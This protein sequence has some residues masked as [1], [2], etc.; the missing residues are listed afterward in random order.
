MP[1]Y[2]EQRRRRWYA[3]LDVP[4]DLRQRLGSS[5][6]IKSLGTESKTEAERLVL[7]LIAEWKA[8]FHATRNLGPEQLAVDFNTQLR[9]RADLEKASGSKGEYE[10]LR[11]VL[12]D[13]FTHMAHHDDASAKIAQKVTFGETFPLENNVEKWLQSL[14]NEP[15]TIDMKRSDLVRLTK[16]FK[17]SHELTKQ[18]VQTWVHKMQVNDALQPATARRIVSSCK[19]YWTYLQVTGCISGGESVFDN[20]SPKKQ[21]KSKSARQEKRKPFLA[22]EVASLL[23]HA[24]E[25]QDIDLARLIWIAMWTGCRIEEICSLKVEDVHSS[26][27]EVKDGKTTAG[28]R[29]VPIHPRLGRLITQLRTNSF[30][31]MLLSGLT[32]NK[33]GDRSNAIGKRFGRL[34]SALGYGEAYVF[35]SIRKTVATEFE[36]AGVTENVAAD[37][38]GHEKNTMTFGVYSGGTRLPNRME[39]ISKLDY[40]VSQVT[41]LRL[42]RDHRSFK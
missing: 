3:V 24:L 1:K 34:K 2:I 26:H 36:N 16:V 37:I 22:S 40:P 11:S 19:G 30:D 14:D 13:K 23:S 12:D 35:H 15:K 25:N 9:W 33:Y 38:L 31:G 41:E 5:R 18:K 20:V 28:N 7:P 29:I 21:S 17:F 4:Q 27:F 42:Y 6:F 39:A 10:I 8:L 32:L